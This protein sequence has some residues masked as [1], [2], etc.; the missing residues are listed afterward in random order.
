MRQLHSLLAILLLVP[1]T[2]RALDVPT[3]YLVQD[4]PLRAGAPSGTNLTF[5]LFDDAACTSMVASQVVAIDAV[6]V[7]SR[8]KSLV[9]RGGTRP[10]KS[11]ELLLTIAGAPEDGPLYLRVT[12][13]GVTP[14]GTAC[15]VQAAGPVAA[16]PIVNLDLVPSTATAGNIL[17]SG[18]RFVHDYGSNNTFVGVG[19]GN[20]SMTGSE[21]VG[22]GNNALAANTTGASNMAMGPYALA[23]NTTGFGNMAMGTGTLFANTTGARNIGIGDLTLG[24]NTTANLNV[25]IGS[26]SLYANTTGDENTAIG[27][28]SLLNNTTG[29]FNV[30]IGGAMR[31]NTVGDFNVAV[32]SA[33]L[34]DSSG[35]D[36]V[37]I[38]KSAALLGTGSRN[39]AVGA[40]AGFFWGSGDDNV[41]IGNVG[42]DPDVGTIRIG[43]PGTHTATYIA[44]ISGATSAGGIAVYV[45]GSGHLGTVT[46]SARYKTDVRDMGEA[47]EALL[48]LRPVSF[49]YDP[50]IDA[51]RLQQYGLIAEE[52]ARVSPELVT[53]DA[54]GR[55]EAVRYHLVNAMLLN[56]VQRQDRRLRAQEAELRSLRARLE[57]LENTRVATVSVGGPR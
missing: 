32:G 26:G 3:R 55:P 13:P 9:P 19:A 34:R 25:A 57:A 12:G 36:N 52:V 42:A 5:D 7:V 16:P 1:S 15:Q 8:L 29:R 45:D 54:E 11:D 56:E 51:S 33:A 37:A 43:S 48:R 6:T 21:N 35:D 30:A 18:A 24:A 10:P 47:S 49:R 4:A 20:F 27:T 38:G 53:Y 39:I 14:I 22:V 46:S 2:V 50:A 28:S 31:D 44:G 17:K 23:S 40:E 41:A